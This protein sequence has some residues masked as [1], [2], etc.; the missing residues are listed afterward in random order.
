MEFLNSR[1]CSRLYSRVDWEPDFKTRLKKKKKKV[2]LPVYNI[3]GSKC[4]ENMTD[5]FSGKDYTARE[6]A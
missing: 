6:E 4:T 2:V 3:V 5:I 1:K